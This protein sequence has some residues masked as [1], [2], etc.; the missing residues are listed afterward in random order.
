MMNTEDDWP[1]KM[2]KN[3]SKKVYGKTKGKLN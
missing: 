1:N 3:D 2:I